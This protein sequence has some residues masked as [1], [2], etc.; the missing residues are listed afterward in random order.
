MST[1]NTYEI[2]LN[3]LSIARFTEEHYAR[4]QTRLLDYITDGALIREL[5][6]H[7]EEEKTHLAQLNRIYNI[8]EEGYDN[9]EYQT[10]RLIADETLQNVSEATSDGAKNLHAAFGFVKAEALEVA[11]YRMIRTMASECRLQSEVIELLAS[12]LNDDENARHSVEQFSIAQLSRMAI[13]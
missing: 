6:S 3:E 9:N 13:E 10:V 8:L 12:N 4:I 2:F 1:A 11:R 5:E 7:L